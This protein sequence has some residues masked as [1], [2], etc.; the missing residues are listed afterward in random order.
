MKSKM[1]LEDTIPIFIEFLFYN[2]V[3]ASFG[4]II[5]LIA[6]TMTFEI[7]IGSFI[8][9]SLIM[10]SANLAL[11]VKVV[12]DGVSIALSS[13]DIQ[14]LTSSPSPPTFSNKKTNL[15]KIKCASCGKL[16]PTSNL[17]CSAC[18]FPIPRPPV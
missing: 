18:H 12:A 15:S 16:N 3:I 13:K 8:I 17:N 9:L 7:Q 11:L 10:T 5:V 4:L 14:N 6:S 1:T 2:L